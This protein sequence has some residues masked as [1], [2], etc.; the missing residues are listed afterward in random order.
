MDCFL[1][2]RGQDTVRPVTL[3]GAGSVAASGPSAPLYTTPSSAPELK[4]R[5]YVDFDEHT[6]KTNNETS[7]SSTSTT[8]AAADLPP[9][10]TLPLGDLRSKLVGVA[11]DAATAPS[12]IT[13][14]TVPTHAPSEF[15]VVAPTDGK[16]EEK[17][18]TT[19]RVVDDEWGT[20]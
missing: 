5:I 9:P 11:H 19:A 20:D 15:F 10:A 1:C 2:G 12:T 18:A 4:G 16:T 13:L 6:E 7:S 17:P 8:T 14:P 3:R